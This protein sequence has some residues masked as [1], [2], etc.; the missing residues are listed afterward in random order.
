MPTLGDQVDRFVVES[1]LGQGGMATVYRVRHAGLGSAHALKVLNVSL[2]SVK[3]RL[4][5]EG[6]LQASLGHPNIVSVTDLLEVEGAPGLIM[7][8]VAGPTLE[9]WLREHV[10]DAATADALFRG[11]L[12]AVAF[13]HRQGLVH[14]DLKPANVLLQDVGGRLVP[15]VADFGLAKLFADGTQPSNTRTGMAM[16]T[17]GYMAPEQYRSAKHVDQRADVYALGC[18]LYDLWC[19]GPAFR[20]ETILQ[21]F[22]AAEQEA[23]EPPRKRRPDLPPNVERAIVGALAAEADRRIPSAEA[24]RAVLD[25]AAAPEAK[26]P[27]AV[28]DAAT[29][30]SVEPLPRA[31]VPPPTSPTMDPPRPAPP[32]GSPMVWVWVAGAAGLVL[33]GAVAVAGVVGVALWGQPPA[34]ATGDAAIRVTGDMDRWW[35]TRD[36][37]TVRARG[38][39]AGTYLVHAGWGPEATEL[40]VTVG[41]GETAEITCA[42]GACA[43][44][45]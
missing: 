22:S 36:G 29:W 20:G 33:A 31:T 3:T 44:A 25:G 42:A 38:L 8:Y 16:G 37:A 45:D 4:V 24:L 5:Q 21:M 11:I 40:E 17:P 26:A 35:V 13:A 34:E 14:R 32:R 43:P 10:P 6:R 28:R 30:E 18:I 19:G 39:P 27:A 1:V 12:D 41:M 2:P 23:Y 7:E 15:K 9:G